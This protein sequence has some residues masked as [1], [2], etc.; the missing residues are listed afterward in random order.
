[1]LDKIKYPPLSYQ[2]GYLDDRN[3]PII[4]ETSLERGTEL[5]GSVIGSR[6]LNVG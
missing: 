6:D 5:G 3:D 4:E 1:M 2:G